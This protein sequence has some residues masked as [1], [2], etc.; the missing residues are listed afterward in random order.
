MKGLGLLS[1][2]GQ[3]QY[4]YHNH[5]IDKDEFLMGFNLPSFSEHKSFKKLFE[6]LI[7]LYLK[8]KVQYANIAEKAE[9][10]VSQVDIEGVREE[11][12]DLTDRKS[13]D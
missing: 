2:E 13:Q 7:E 1:S 11:E 12:G 4:Q 5:L 10:D 3:T 9:S 6:P 8:L